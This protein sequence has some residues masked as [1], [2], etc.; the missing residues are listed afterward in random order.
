[1]SEQDGRRPSAPVTLLERQID[2]ERIARRAY[3]IYES[4]NRIEGYADDDWFQAATEY[5]ARDT[6]TRASAGSYGASRSLAD[7]VRS[8]RR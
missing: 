5:S 6:T 8:A 7:R 3:E 4:R 2:D 1:M